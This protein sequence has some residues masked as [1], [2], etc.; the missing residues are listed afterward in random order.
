VSRPPHRVG[1]FRTPPPPP[2]PPPLVDSWAEN[3]NA[4]FAAPHLYRAWTCDE[5]KQST[6]DER[7][8]VTEFHE[9]LSEG[10]WSIFIINPPEFRTVYSSRTK[11]ESNTPLYV[12][13][14]YARSLQ[15]EKQ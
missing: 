14:A 6:R 8:A 7:S 13:A 15:K 9:P 3:K 12:R 11:H 1:A 4:V 10:R 2:E 5:L